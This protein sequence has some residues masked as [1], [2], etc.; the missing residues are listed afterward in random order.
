MADTLTLK[1]HPLV[2]DWIARRTNE[3][4]AMRAGCGPYVDAFSK[5]DH[6]IHRIASLILYAAERHGL[7]VMFKAPRQCLFEH[8]GVV[9]TCVLVAISDRIPGTASLETRLQVTLLE[10]PLFSTLLD[11]WSDETAPLEQQFCEIARCIFEHAR[12]RARQRQQEARNEIV[13]QMN[14]LVAELNDLDGEMGRIRQFA[15]SGSVQGTG[16]HGCRD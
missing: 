3:R 4:R 5:M 1:H 7:I 10:P 11:R 12:E 6:R 2:A 16:H 9:F 15:W 13:H 8:D 14:R